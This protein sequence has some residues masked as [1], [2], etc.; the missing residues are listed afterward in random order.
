MTYF[1]KSSNENF[2][3][4]IDKNKFMDILIIPDLCYL[5]KETQTKKI[6]NILSINKKISKTGLHHYAY[7]LK[8]SNIALMSAYKSKYLQKKH[9]R[10]N[11]RIIQSVFSF[12]IYSLKKTCVKKIFYFDYTEV[13]EVQAEV[14]RT[15]FL[16]SVLTV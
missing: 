10:A 7:V 8:S 2:G 13:A 6:L 1:S 5:V 14:I 3:N 11:Y 15:S 12:L 9:N 16:T 4:Q